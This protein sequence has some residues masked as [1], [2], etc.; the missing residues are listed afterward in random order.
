MVKV[1]GFVIS[2]MVTKLAGSCSGFVISFVA[3]V[4]VVL[5]PVSVWVCDF[6]H[7]FSSCDTVSGL[8][9]SAMVPILVVLK[10]L[11]LHEKSLR[12]HNSESNNIATINFSASNP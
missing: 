8:V 3:T 1:S 2:V 9:I 7:G 4:L 11:V 12:A 5:I 10:N 6:C